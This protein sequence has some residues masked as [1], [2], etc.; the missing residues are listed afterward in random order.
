MFPEAVL[1]L[2]T[3]V[4]ALGTGVDVYRSITKPG[5][6]AMVSR[7]KLRVCANACEAKPNRNTR[8]HADFPTQIMLARRRHAAQSAR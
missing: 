6:K 4:R 7:G 2:S 5:G 1:L 8:Q 3:K